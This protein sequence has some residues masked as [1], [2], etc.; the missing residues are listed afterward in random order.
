ML[1]D[2]EMI[3]REFPEKNGIR[4]YPIFDIHLG[5]RESLEKE[6]TA[7]SKRIL[8]EPNS[9][10]VLGGDL[11]NNGTLSSVTNPFEEIYRPREQKK[12]M[13]EMLLPLKDRILCAVQG[14]HERRNRD[15][16]NDII[17][18]IMCKL[19]IEDLYRE[20]IAFLSISFGNKRNNS[21]YNP[22]YTFAV[23]HGAGGGALTGG[24]VNR[25][26]RFAYSMS[27]VDALIV[28]H[29]HKPLVTSPAQLVVDHQNRKVY[30]KP[31]KVIVATSWLSWG[32]YAAQKLL[33]PTA[34]V[35]QIVNLR[36]DQKELTITM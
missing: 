11:I 22:V 27:G 12:I 7:F 35:P 17:Y 30:V 32:G 15:V 4:I 36:G 9:Y 14:N 31:F 18:D 16:D 5:A 2:F 21:R 33:T 23:S 6:W 3:V 25:A 24:G 28:G 29:T 13:T 8:N 26:E 19:D 20:N 1:S 34:H 10:L